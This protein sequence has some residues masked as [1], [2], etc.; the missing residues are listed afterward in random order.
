MAVPRVRSIGGQIPRGYRPGRF[1]T[2]G[3]LTSLEKSSCRVLGLRSRR[4]RYCRKRRSHEFG[5]IH[6]NVLLDLLD[7][8][9]KPVA[10]AR[11]CPAKWDL[12][13]VRLSI[14]RIVDLRGVAPERSFSV[15]H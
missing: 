14:I 7:L 12:H 5:I 6:R 4:F 10:G 15:P 8:N 2:S 1:N 9:G 13:A 11:E 3:G